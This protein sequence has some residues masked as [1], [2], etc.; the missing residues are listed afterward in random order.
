MRSG[1]EQAFASEAPSAANFS[2]TFCRAAPA[3]AGS[4]S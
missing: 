4:S 2:F 1:R 3:D